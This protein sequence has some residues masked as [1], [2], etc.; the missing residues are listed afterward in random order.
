M[1]DKEKTMNSFFKK[2]ILTFLVVMIS[3]SFPLKS[4][5]DDFGW[6]DED[7]FEEETPK[8]KFKTISK[9]ISK[10][11]SYKKCVGNGCD[12]KKTSRSLE[13]LLQKKNLELNELKIL[14]KTIKNIIFNPFSYNL[15]SVVDTSDRKPQSFSC[16]DSPFGKFNILID[17]YNKVFDHVSN[18]HIVKNKI[19]FKSWKV[20]IDERILLMEIYSKN[21]NINFDK[22]LF[23]CI[24]PSHP[25]VSIYIDKALI[26]K[27]SNLNVWDNEIKY[28][29]LKSFRKSFIKKVNALNKLK[30]EKE[31]SKNKWS[32]RARNYLNALYKVQLTRFF[33]EKVSHKIGKPSFESGAREILYKGTGNSLYESLIKA[34]IIYDE[35]KYGIDRYLKD[36]DSFRNFSKTIKI[37][38]KEEIN[39][40]RK[41]SKIFRSRVL[42]FSPGIYESVSDRKQIFIE[43]EEIYFHPLAL[44]RTKFPLFITANNYHNPWIEYITNKKDTSDYS[45]TIRVNKLN[46]KKEISSSNDFKDSLFDALFSDEGFTGIPIFRSNGKNQNVKYC[47]K[48]SREPLNGSESKPIQIITKIKLNSALLNNSFLKGGMGELLIGDCKNKKGTSG[49]K[50]KFEIMEDI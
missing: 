37:N 14:N 33:L 6:D 28:K 8:S 42:N 20:L 47:E 36:L 16:N 29:G 19:D 23:E 13:T 1:I 39:K 11:S 30:K 49:K 18:L 45:F 44:L 35:E 21:I 10:F 2:A 38:L 24:P 4:Q 50:G 40:P 9:T 15:D 43:A 41:K 31:I 17:R 34:L 3:F 26:R 12:V 25:Y 22:G 32:L 5:D 48:S 46:N 27:G 7:T